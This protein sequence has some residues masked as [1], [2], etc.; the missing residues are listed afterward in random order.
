M[1]K[2]LTQ[3]ALNK[4]LEKAREFKSEIKKNIAVAGSAAFAFLIALAWRDAIT[5]SVNQMIESL[6][7]PEIAYLYKFLT[8]FIIT[9]VCILGIWATSKIAAKEETKIK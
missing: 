1:V 2:E 6:N 3:K 4:S 7:I 8:A 9:A 5:E